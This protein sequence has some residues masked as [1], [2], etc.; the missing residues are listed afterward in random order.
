VFPFP[1]TCITS[2][3]QA[4]KTPKA[5]I[6]SL[7]CIVDFVFLLSN[8]YRFS[9]FFL[10]TSSKCGSKTGTAAIDTLYIRNIHYALQGRTQAC[11]SVD[12]YS[13]T[14]QYQTYLSYIFIQVYTAACTP[15]W[16]AISTYFLNSPATQWKR[17]LLLFMYILTAIL[18][19]SHDSYLLSL[20]AD[21]LAYKNSA[22]LEHLYSVYSY[23]ESYG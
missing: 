17:A 2:L 4:N 9:H 10:F 8:I 22:N 12:E 21:T 19:F 16:A 20:F 18:I 11:V 6:Q 3:K 7:I 1:P 23:F 14:R 15:Q 5:I 13:N